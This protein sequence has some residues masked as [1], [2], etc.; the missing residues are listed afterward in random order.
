MTLPAKQ[1]RIN[2]LTTQRRA[3]VI[4]AEP[5]WAVVQD[6]TN[7]QVQRLNRW[8]IALIAGLAVLTAFGFY[9]AHKTS[10]DLAYTAGKAEVQ[11][12]VIEDLRSQRDENAAQQQQ[13]DGKGIGQLIVSI[14]SNVLSII[15]L[16][17]TSILEIV[18]EATGS[19]A[20]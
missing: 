1:K 10:V 6:S 5:D 17:V 9:Q 12:E 3:R 11:A 15:A 19:P 8:V 4:Q 13:D 14:I 16:V 2:H 18:A 20:T 7:D